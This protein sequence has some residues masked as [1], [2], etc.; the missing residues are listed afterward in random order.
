MVRE[1]VGE[2]ENSK[3]KVLYNGVDVGNM[4]DMMRNQDIIETLLD[5]IIAAVVEGNLLEFT[6]DG[7]TKYVAFMN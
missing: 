4:M 5:E 1:A 6:V 3:A 2:S 7:E